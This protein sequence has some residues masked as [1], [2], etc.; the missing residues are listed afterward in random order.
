MDIPRHLEIAIAYKKAGLKEYPG[1]RHNP[2]V[3]RLFHLCG[4][5]EIK[6]DE[7]A[8]C[9]AFVGGCLAEAERQGTGS[10]MA[11]SYMRW[12]VPVRKKAS[13]I[14]PGDVVVMDRGSDKRFGHVE[15]VKR[16]LPN[17]RVECLGGNVKNM[18]KLTS[19]PIAGLLAVRRAPPVGGARPVLP[20]VTDS[21]TLSMQFNGLL[22]ALGSAIYTAWDWLSTTASA[23]MTLL[24]GVADTVSTTVGAGQTITTSAGLEWPSI[25]GFAFAAVCFATAFGRLLLQRL[26]VIE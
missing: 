12:G 21:P 1:R 16:V 26:G 15:F 4:H 6:T 20:T 25:L 3:L 19:R 7:T 10:L 2:D 18:V 24:P 23:A 5:P 11:K 17:N 13:A 9:A 8:W 22:A 14:L